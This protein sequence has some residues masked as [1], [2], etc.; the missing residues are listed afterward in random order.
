MRVKIIKIGN[1]KGIMFSKQL[2]SQF[3][4][5]REAEIVT[6]DEGILIKP[7]K[8]QPRQNWEKQ[9]EEAMSIEEEQ[10]GEL[11]EGFENEFDKTEWKW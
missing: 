3:N 5:E 7:V 2:I 9:F 10:E 8:D 6:N 4:F 1:S 11:L